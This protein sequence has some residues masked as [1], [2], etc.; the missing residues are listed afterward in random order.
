VRAG[1]TGLQPSRQPDLRIGLCGS[2]RVPAARG[3]AVALRV[4]PLAKP[5]VSPLTGCRP[6]RNMVRPAE[7]AEACGGPFPC[8]GIAGFVVRPAAQDRRPLGNRAGS[9]VAALRSARCSAVPNATPVTRHARSRA[10]EDRIQRSARSGCAAAKPAISG[11]TT[12]PFA[13]LGGTSAAEPPLL[14]IVRSVSLQP[15]RQ[16]SW[17]IGRDAAPPVGRG[18][19]CASRPTA[20]GDLLAVGREAGSLLRLLRTPPIPHPFP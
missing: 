17:H 12:V 7:P 14:A 10:A 9:Q 6:S 5:S 1:Q 4:E 18:S 11:S 2:G 3:R 16:A 20:W 19:P 15:L 8:P 13:A